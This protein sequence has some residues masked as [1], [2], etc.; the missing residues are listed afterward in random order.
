MGTSLANYLDLLLGLPAVE[1]G[2]D[3][4]SL[5]EFDGR[6]GTMKNW[7]LVFVF[8]AVPSTCMGSEQLNQI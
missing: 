7:N 4:H 5:V 3:D 2:L 8:D 1:S 6:A